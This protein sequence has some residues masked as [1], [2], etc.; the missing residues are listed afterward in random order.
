MSFNSD[1]RPFNKMEMS[2]VIIELKVG[3]S[4]RLTVITKSDF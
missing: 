1:V 4:K 2:P 3:L